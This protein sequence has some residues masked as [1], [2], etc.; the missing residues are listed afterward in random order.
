MKGI[1]MFTLVKRSMLAAAITATFFGAA[2]PAAAQ[3]VTTDRATTTAVLAPPDL[4]D[5]PPDY[6]CLWTATRWTGQRWQGHG[7]NQPLPDF[8]NNKSLSSLN[9]DNSRIACLWREQIGVGVVM[10]EA[11]G[12]RR[13]DLTLDARPDHGNWAREFSA[14]SWNC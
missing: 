7:V 12:S 1:D 6:V 13:A 14:Q 5:C 3:P 11:P 2:T 4:V 10:R 9:N 8:I